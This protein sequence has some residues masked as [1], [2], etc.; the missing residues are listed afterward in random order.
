MIDILVGT[1]PN[2]IKVTQFRRVAKN[3]GI[4]I[5]LIHT[6]QHFQKEMSDV[7]FSE[8]DIFPDYSLDIGSLNP[9]LQLAA[10]FQG[11]DDLYKGITLPEVLIVP[12]DV[13]S[14]LAGAIYANKCG[15]KLAHLEAGL[16]SFDRTMPEEHNRIVADHLSDFLFVTEPSGLVNIRREHLK[17]QVFYTGNTMIDTLVHFKEKIEASDVHDR[18]SIHKNYGVITI[19]RPSNV[20]THEGLSLVLEV[21]RGICNHGALVWPVHPR[22]LH[23]LKKFGL[24]YELKAVNNL[25]V[26]PP[27]G[28]LDFQKLLAHCDFV[29]TDSGGVQEETTYLMKPCLTLRHSTERPVTITEGSNVLLPFA[30]AQIAREVQ[31]VYNGTFKKGKIPD[32]WDGRATERVLAAL[33]NTQS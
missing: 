16:R 31:S 12:G 25:I 20:D 27:L 13:N 6:G 7:F 3:L 8:L 23:A 28:Y 2:F 22:T 21:L 14:T 29:L 5:R 18:L 26:S 11:L 33:L 9:P 10:I 17:A 30:S 19:H 24:M 32:Y 1:R 15:L 4:T